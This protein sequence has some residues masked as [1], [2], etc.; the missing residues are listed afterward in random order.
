MASI[1]RV[2]NALLGQTTQ[3]GIQQGQ[4]VCL[5]LLRRALVRLGLVAVDVEVA[6]GLWQL[7]LAND[8]MGNHDKR[9]H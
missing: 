4:S 8:E 9:A 2:S 6:G 1:A 7:A 5:R 3:A